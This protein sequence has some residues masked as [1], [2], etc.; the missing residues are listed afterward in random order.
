MRFKNAEEKRTY[1]LET[2]VR[3]LVC[4]LAGPTIFSMLITSF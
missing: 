1:M 2:P 3:K 4:T